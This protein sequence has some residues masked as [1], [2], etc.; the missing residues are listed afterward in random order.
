MTFTSLPEVLF[1]ICV[2]LVVYTY[3]VYPLAIMLAARFRPSPPD[4]AEFGAKEPVSVIMAAYNEEVSIGRRVHEL[5]KL[6]A[7]A[8][9]SASPSPTTAQ[10]SSDGLSN[11]AP[12]ACDSA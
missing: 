10:T 4:N 1:W 9:V 7:S 2:V 3:F 5:A 6:V 8:P 12:Y 11:A